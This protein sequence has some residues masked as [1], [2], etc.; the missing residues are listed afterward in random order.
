LLSARKRL[1][2]RA[3]DIEW[4]YYAGQFSLVQSRDVTAA[5]ARDP[6]QQQC[7]KCGASRRSRVGAEP[8]EIVFAKNE[9]SEMLP[10]PTPLSLSLMEALWAGGG[11]VDLAARQLGFLTILTRARSSSSRSSPVYVDRREERARAIAITGSR[12]AVCCDR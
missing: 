10:R 11:S 2:G 12:H 6:I 7:S 9:L 1:F 5:A 4:V 8:D 3:Q